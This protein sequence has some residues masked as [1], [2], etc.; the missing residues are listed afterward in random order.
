MPSIGLAE[1]AIILVALAPL[2]LLT[3]IAVAILSG[4][5][6]TSR[7]RGDQLDRIEQRLIELEERIERGPQ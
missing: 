4:M 6:N 5:R 3:V 7:R 2:I 1:L